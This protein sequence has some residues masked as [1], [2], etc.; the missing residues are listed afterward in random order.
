[1]GVAVSLV[2]LLE[3]V[4]EVSGITLL[5]ASTKRR[6]RVIA[7]TRDMLFA[8][9]EFSV[10][11]GAKGT[12]VDTGFRGE[13]ALQRGLCFLTFGLGFGRYSRVAPRLVKVDALS[14]H[15]P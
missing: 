6:I 12:T 7:L 1:M 2:E 9:M 13:L 3:G 14:G 5:R 8:V 15:R 4:F 11:P 10:A